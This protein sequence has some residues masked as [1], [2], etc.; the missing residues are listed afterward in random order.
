MTIHYV[1]VYFNHCNYESRKRNT[2]NFMKT[3]GDRVHLIEIAYGSEPFHIGHR[4]S[5]QIRKE[6][7]EGWETNRVI[8][9]YI[10]KHYDANF[11]ALVMIDSDLELYNQFFS[12]VPIMLEQNRE[13]L[14]YIQPFSTAIETWNSPKIKTP[15]QVSLA[16][17]Y[18]D[19]NRFD[20]S[21]HT[22]Y[23]YIYPKKFLEKIDFRLPTS[24]VLGGWDTVL[25]YSVLGLYDD[26]KKI[27]PIHEDY[28]DVYQFY[29][30]IQGVKLEYITGTVYHHEH[31]LS[32]VQRY[33]G[34][35]KRY[36][37]LTQ[38]GILNYF[39]SRQE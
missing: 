5:T 34:R 25:F 3:Y 21:A 28:Q 22:G 6:H 9:E 39:W 38:E 8:N 11:E 30:K 4:N 35:F 18:H 13:S 27:I 33:I 12:L 19:F 32:K 10:L 1:S 37:N 17:F 29:H 15:P 23:I 36:E 7:F 2:L 20:F 14:C 16:K 24:L 26:L 31:G